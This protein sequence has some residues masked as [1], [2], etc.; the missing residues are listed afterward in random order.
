M[1]DLIEVVVPQPLLIEVGPLYG[2]VFDGGG[3]GVAD[4]NKGDIIVSG[5]GAIWTLDEGVVTLS[6]MADLAT[7]TI[8][9]RATVGT[10]EPEALTPAQIRT[11][12]NVA[13]GATANSS[14][15]SL[16][17]RS[18]HTG[19]QD[20][21]TIAGLAAVATSGSASDLGIG[22][23]PI[24]RIADS[25]V[26][27]AKLASIAASTILGNNTGAGAAP[28]ALTGTQATTLL[29]TFTSALKGL[30]PASGGGTTNFLRADG[31][32]AAPGGGGTPGGSSDEVQYNNGGAFAGATGVKIEGGQMRL[33]SILTPSVPAAGGVKVF[34]K[35]MGNAPW[36]HFLAPDGV[37]PWPVQ[38]Y[39]GDGRFY[40]W[41]PIVGGT[42]ASLIGWPAQ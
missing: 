13:D 18:T 19:T 21:G 42:T 40:A 7:S 3:G 9:G 31:T 5:T 35:D 16:R 11:M 8:L 30:A 39:V 38:P 2:A 33:P 10:G 32:W 1:A 6:K 14:D 23:L 36:P 27:L 26:T 28:T 37:V 29:D 24:A 34:G 25:S 22:T 41:L 15:V 4:G 12:L 20:A 17:D